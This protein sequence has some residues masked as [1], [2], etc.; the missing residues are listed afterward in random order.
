MMLLPGGDER[1]LI[2]LPGFMTSPD[3]YADL[4]QPIA[5]TGTSVCV[6]QLYKRGPSALLGK[7]S[8]SSEADAAAELVRDAARRNPRVTVYLGGHSR[9]GQAAWLAASRLAPDLPAGLVLLDP[10]DGEGRNPSA[11]TSTASGA[12]VVCRTLIIGAG[13]GGRCAPEPVN[14]TVF[15]AATPGA[16]HIVVEQLGHADMLTGRSRD[17]GRKLCPGAHDPDPGR[18]EC[19]ALIEGFIRGD[20]A[21][22]LESLPNEQ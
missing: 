10:V 6:P 20:D 15:L 11:P 5:D 2:F 8:V 22:N 21:T 12:Q 19:S 16:S 7:V 13:I 14:H 18:A 9:G 1:L 3:A 4:L 17:F